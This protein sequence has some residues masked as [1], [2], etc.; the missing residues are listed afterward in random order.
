MFSNLAGTAFEGRL[1]LNLYAIIATIIHQNKGKKKAQK[2]NQ[3]R[4]Q[5]PIKRE[6]RDGRSLALI[7][8][9]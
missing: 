5:S 7:L 9:K 1:I 2:T 4:A 8:D 6:A 3:E